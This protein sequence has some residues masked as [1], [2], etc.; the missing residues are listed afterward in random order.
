MGLLVA[1]HETTA[2][3]IAL[4]TL[5]LLRHPGQLTRIRDTDDPAVLANVVEEL[6]RYLT[7]AQDVV[8]RVATEDLTIGGQLIRAGEGLMMNL[9]AGNRDAGI[10]EQPDT[11]DIDGNSRS[12]LAFGYGVH[13]CIGQSLARVELQIALSTLLRRLPGLR[14]AVPMEQVNFRHDMTVYG[15]H[16]LPVAW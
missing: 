14:L 9:P 5:T 15:V 1:G 4:G 3:M 2:N 16:E 12:H 7:I 8:M 13:Q 10:F 11:L 6:L